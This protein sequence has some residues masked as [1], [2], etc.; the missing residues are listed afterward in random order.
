MIDALDVAT[1]SV[2]NKNDQ[3]A[4]IERQ[5]AEAATAAIAVNA[6]P[7][8]K[9]SEKMRLRLMAL[10]GQ[11]TLRMVDRSLTP[12]KFATVL[13]MEPQFV[14][15]LMCGSETTINLTKLDE[16]AQFF[17]TEFAFGFFGQAVAG[18]G[19]VTAAQQ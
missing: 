18:P 14:M 4:G 12:E 17:E 1:F 11:L 10:G 3:L 7:V 6:A 16:I 8:C 9:I 13:Q 15:N 19:R 5:L 2:D